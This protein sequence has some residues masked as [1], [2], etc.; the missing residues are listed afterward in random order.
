MSDAAGQANALA[1]RLNN[2]VANNEKL[3]RHTI[4]NLEA[5]STMMADRK[6]DVASIV[7]DVRGLSARLNEISQKVDNAVDRLA[8]TASDHPE[9]V[10]SQVQQARLLFASCPKNS[11]NPWATSPAS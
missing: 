5:F 11:T 1:V 10:V 6:D 9:S 7:Q 3:L 8:G 4:T 2:L